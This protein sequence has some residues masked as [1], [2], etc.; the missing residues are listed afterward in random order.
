MSRKKD[1]HEE[2]ITV[3]VGLISKEQV[4]DIFINTNYDETFNMLRTFALGLKL[5]II[6]NL[7]CLENFV[8]VTNALTSGQKSWTMTMILRKIPPYF[9]PILIT[10]RTDELVNIVNKIS[11]GTLDKSDLDKMFGVIFVQTDL[12]CKN[13]TTYYLFNDGD[14][15]GAIDELIRGVLAKPLAIYKAHTTKRFTTEQV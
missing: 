9:L 8:A 3:D 7:P 11:G 1:I 14:I 2:N 15:D 10:D 5:I 6:G 13:P 12:D 4:D